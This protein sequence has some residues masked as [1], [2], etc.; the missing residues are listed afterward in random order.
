MDQQLAPRVLTALETAQAAAIEARCGMLRLD[1]GRNNTLSALFYVRI[2]NVVSRRSNSSDMSTHV[3]C[4][5]DRRRGEVRDR[6]V[7][8]ELALQRG[9]GVHH[10]GGGEAVVAADGAVRVLRVG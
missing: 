6:R 3:A 9:R 10:L 1:A 2:R 8:G 4:E 5:A 7:V